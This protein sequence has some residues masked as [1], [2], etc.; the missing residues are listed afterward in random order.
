ML[1]GDGGAGYSFNIPGGT[2]RTGVWGGLA[3]LSLRGGCHGGMVGLAAISRI[4]RLHGVIG[5]PITSLR[6]GCGGTV[7]VAVL[8]T[9]GGR[10]GAMGLAVLYLRGGGVGVMRLVVF[11]LRGGGV[12]VMGLAVLYLRGGCVGVVRLVAFSLRG[13][14]V[15]VV[16]LVLLSMRGGSRRRWGRC[17]GAR[18]VVPTRRSCW[19]SWACANVVMRCRR[20]V[21][22]QHFRVTRRWRRGG[23]WDLRVGWQQNQQEQNRNDCDR[24]SRPGSFGHSGSVAHQD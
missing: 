16:E 18:R 7:W 4:G 2:R 6:G 10:V 3:V 5:L 1:G 8:S 21:R 23:S 9:R 12:G 24:S 15:G 14:R 22:V 19:W 17:D 11:S 20:P 13:G